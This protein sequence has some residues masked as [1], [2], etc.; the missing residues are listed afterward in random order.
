MLKRMR[1]GVVLCLIALTISRYTEA[2][3]RLLFEQRVALAQFKT[4]TTKTPFENMDELREA[5]RRQEIPEKNLPFLLE[6]TGA[7]TGVYVL[8]HGFGQNPASLKNLAAFYQSMG[9]HVVGILL[10]GQGYKDTI[11]GRNKHRKSLHTPDKIIDAWEAQYAEGVQIAKLYNL[12]VIAGG[13]SMGATLGLAYAI[14]NPGHISAVAANSLTLDAHK[15]L[16]R[17]AKFAQPRITQWNTANPH[18]SPDL[19]PHHWTEA[20]FDP[21]FYSELA[22]GYTRL[23]ADSLSFTKR[24]SER[25]KQ[26]L[27]DHAIPEE[28]KIHITYMETDPT[29]NVALLRE[30][31]PSSHQ[32][33][34]LQYS[35]QDVHRLLDIKP[36]KKVPHE[37]TVFAPVETL[38]L[39]LRPQ[40]EFVNAAID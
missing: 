16:Y 22:P 34:H 8:P 21:L 33:I 27:L 10:E 39:L 12:P 14:H 29:I 31:L 3:C 13:F 38:S 1:Y 6:A 18:L 9:F 4:D 23:A 19:N 28:L 37:L 5:N 11:E 15:I 36:D 30:L 2:S 24:F 17:L 25:I 26:T 7:V 20:T 35:N 32:I 40:V